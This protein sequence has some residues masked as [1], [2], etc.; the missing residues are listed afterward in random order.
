MN[1]DELH[2]LVNRATFPTERAVATWQPMT[3]AAHQAAAE[4]RL[5][6]WCHLAA[7]GD[8]T[9]FTARLAWAGLTVDQARQLVTAGQPATRRPLPPWATIILAALAQAAPLANGEEPTAV[10][11]PFLAVAQATLART[12][13]DHLAWLTPLAQDGLLAALQHALADLIAPTLAMTPLPTL[14]DLCHTYPVLARQLAT[15]VIQWIE[16]CVEFLQRLAADWPSLMAVTGQAMA[17]VPGVVRD[18][19]SDLSD[20]H[21]NG[22]TVWAVTLATQGSG[23]TVAYKPKPITQDHAWQALLAWCNAQGVCPPLAHLWTLPRAGY[24]WMAWAAGEPGIVAVNTPCY[25][26]RVGMILGLLQLLHAADCHAE[27]LVTQGEQLLLVD[28]EMVRY[29]QIAGQTEADPLDVLRTGLLPRWVVKPQGV[30]EIG[31]LCAGA[32]LSADAATAI[33][34]GYQGIMQFLTAQWSQLKATAGPLAA[35]GRGPVRFSPRPTAA[36]LRL[37]DHLRQPGY[38]R[39]GADFTIGADQLARTY[40]QHPA[41]HPFAALLT[42]EHAALARGDVPRFMVQIGQP[43]FRVDTVQVNSLLHWPALALPSAA[44]QQQQQWLIGETLQRAPY[45]TAPDQADSFLDHALQ[46]GTILLQRAVPVAGGA[47]G[48]LAPQRQLR[49]GCHQHALMGDD[50]YGGR[51]GIA[52]FLAALYAATGTD[53]WRAAALA[54]LKPSISMPT[55]NIGQQCYALLHCAQLLHEPTLLPAA[56]QGIDQLAADPILVSGPSAASTWGVLDGMA[57]QLLTLLQVYHQLA[58]ITVRQ[59]ALRLAITWGD[60]LC[61]QQAA[62]CHPTTGLGG[63]AHG[64]AGIAY[65]L[66]ALYTASGEIRFRAAAQQGWAF[67]QQLYRTPLDDS[68]GNWQDRRGTTPVYLDNW[69]NGAAGIG[70]AAAASV[71]VCPTQTV[72]VEQAAALLVDTTPLSPLA[73]LCC[74]RFGQIECL[75]EMGLLTAHPQWI[76]HATVQARTAVA[77]AEVAGHFPLYDDLP[78]QLFNPTFFR[79]VAGIGYTLLRLAAANGEIAGKLPC[80][81]RWA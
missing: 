81:L 25:Y 5:A 51:A 64:A 12:G 38:L 29:P 78:P 70:L 62:W 24:G 46:L 36:Y 39:D 14:A 37:L 48:W 33:P 54:A 22:R 34:I 57:G 18:L 50:L 4:A 53:G 77:Q 80:V 68:R 72:V 2:T 6:R 55:V 40:L 74:G 20:R 63:F 3:S 19:R 27:N 9:L 43:D 56:V 60:N 1:Q 73:T 65:A 71:A 44:M 30:A 15:R 26:R 49:S 35:F 16:A 67:Q 75:L 28:A 32:S 52:L 58:N 69:C 17:L 61:A 47:L 59:S 41:H 8:W 76:T 42:A 79:G 45:L 23:M 21:D 66:A 13:G 10:V 7:G 11:Q 31:G